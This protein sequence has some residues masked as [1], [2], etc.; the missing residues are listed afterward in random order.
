MATDKNLLKS[1][2]E[3]LSR[4]IYDRKDYN[5]SYI[6]TDDYN[7]SK[8]IYHKLKKYPK[9]FIKEA[10]EKSIDY[11]TAKNGGNLG[12][13]LEDILPVVIL[14]QIKKLQKEEISKPFKFK[15]KWIIVKFIDQREAKISKFEDA[16]ESLIKG[17]TIKN[18][19]NFKNKI[20]KKANI[21]MIVK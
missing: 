20:I 19:Q 9:L 12:F 10:K 14:N 8:N 13:V 4:I 1:E 2:Y 15:D 3:K 6:I 16:K 17:L 11:Q 7:I 21:K 18:I 5:V